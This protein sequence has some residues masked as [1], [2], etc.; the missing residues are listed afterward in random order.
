MRLDKYNI[1]IGDIAKLNKPYRYFLQ[2]DVINVIKY[3]NNEIWY[4]A[5]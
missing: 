4:S 1:P 3:N 2:N 5:T